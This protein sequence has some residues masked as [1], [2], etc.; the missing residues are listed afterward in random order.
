MT[1]KVDDFKRILADPA[2]PREE[3]IKAL[4]FLVHFVQDMH[5]P[6]H[7]GHRD[8]KGGNDLQVQFFGKG[9]NLHSVWDSGLLE[10][11]GRAEPEYV[12]ALESRITPELVEAWTKGATRDWADESLQAAKVAY[13]VPGAE[14]EQ[15]K[16]GAK[17]GQPY[18]DANIAAAERRVLQAG[19]RLAAILN[20][21]FP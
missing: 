21:I 17:L 7:V 6:V 10:K 4:K 13:R 1:A 20:E 15:L 8:D 3:R 18:Q 12:K 9:S 2:T 16:K 5:Q 11:D 19:V 14:D